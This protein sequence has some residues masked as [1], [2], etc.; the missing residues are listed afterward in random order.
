MEYLTTCQIVDRLVGVE[1]TKK[2]P[3]AISSN[4]RILI[5]VK[6]LLMFNKLY[7]FYDSYRFMFCLSLLI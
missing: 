1:Q 5:D 7:C 6:H 2:K 3:C 4:W